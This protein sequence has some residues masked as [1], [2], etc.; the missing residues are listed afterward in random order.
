M[1]SF[2]DRGNRIGHLDAD[3][4][5]FQLSHDVDHLGIANIGNVFLEC[6]AEDRHRRIGAAPLQQGT[7]AFPRNPFTH[8]VIDAPAGKNDLRMIT[9]LFGAKGQIVW[10]NADAVSADKTWLEVHEIP[11]RRRSGEHIAGVDAELMKNCGQF[12]HE[13]DIE[14]ALGIL[15]YFGGFGDLDRRR[16]V[17]ARF[18]DRT[19]NIRDNVEGVHILRGHALAYTLKAVCRVARIDPFGRIADGEIAATGK[20]R[21]LFEDGQA[22]FLDGARVYGRFIN[23]DVAAL[24]H[25]ADDFGGGQNGT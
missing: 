21:V 6:H 9:G 4:Y 5:A 14:I 15:D 8:A 19:I 25:F 12:V 18:H 2:F 3:T 13:R 11:F 23:N 17:D 24:E 22:F 10:V 20:P 1:G 16:A 7:H